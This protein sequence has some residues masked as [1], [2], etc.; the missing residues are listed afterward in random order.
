VEDVQYRKESAK[1]LSDFAKE[2]YDMDKWSAKRLKVY[3]DI[4]K[5]N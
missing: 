4:L 2:H 1:R 5:K 3:K